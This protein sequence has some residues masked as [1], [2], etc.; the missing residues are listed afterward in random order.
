MTSPWPYRPRG[1]SA[2]EEREACAVSG[3]PLLNAVRG[4]VRD[5]FNQHPDYLT[6]YGQ[7]RSNAERSIVKRV[8]GALKGLGVRTP[9]G[10]PKRPACASAPVQGQHT[11]PEGAGTAGGGGGLGSAPAFRTC[12]GL[13]RTAQKQNGTLQDS[14]GESGG[15]SGEPTRIGSAR[16][17]EAPP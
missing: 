3:D 12:G 10:R 14:V 16:S 1:E 2:Q 5:A 4:A 8:L 7:F 15:L 6:I 9:G 17:P 13:R 11:G